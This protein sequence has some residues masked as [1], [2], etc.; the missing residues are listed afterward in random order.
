MPRTVDRLRVTQLI[1]DERK[2]V[3]QAFS[4]P[5][6]ALEWGPDGC[7]MVSFKADMRVGG[8]FRE[9]MDCGGQ[10]HTAHGVYK[11]IIPGRTVVFTHQWAGEQPVETL[12][13]FEFKDKK[14][15]TEIVLTQTGFRDASE[16]K[17][18]EEGWSSALASFANLLEAK[19]TGHRARHRPTARGKASSSSRKAIA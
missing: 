6:L 8:K 1:R 19:G 12:V 3:F 13:T 5:K 7:R 15:G 17:G 9:S 4:D 14:G 10:R 2:R 16:A 11:K 18:H